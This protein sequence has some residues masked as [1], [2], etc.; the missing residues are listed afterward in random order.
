MIPI[1]DLLHLKP[2]TTVDSRVL[3]ELL[4]LAFAGRDTDRSI[5]Q[6]MATTTESSPWNAEFFGRDLFLDSLIEDVCRLSFASKQYAVHR[7]FLVRTLASP[8][9]DREEIRF[10]QEI[11][12]ELATRDE[13]R[14]GAVDLYTDLYDLMNMFKVPGRQARLD[15]ETFRVDLLRLAKGAVDHMVERFADAESGLRRL[16]TVGREIQ[17]SDDYRVL[18]ALVDHVDHRVT[19]NVDLQIGSAGRLRSVKVRRVDENRD[20]P[21][22][23]SPLARWW[24]K[25]RCFFSYGSSL[26]DE[27]ILSRLVVSVF[28]SLGP[29]LQH[30]LQVLVHLELYLTN[31]SLKERAEAAGLTVCLAD[32]S[33]TPDET[34]DGHVWR[35]LF[36]PLL[37]KQEAVP[38]PCGLR[39]PGRDGITLLTGPNSGGKT[40]FLQALGLAQVLGQSGLYTCASEARLNLLRGLYVSLIE[41]EA[42]DH[43]EGRLGRE[44][45]RIRTMFDAM[46]PPSM[47]ILDELC[48][49][50]NPS[51]ATEVFSMVLELLSPLAPVAFI[52]TH[53][54]DYAQQLETSPPVDNLDFLQV[55]MGA[56]QR[57]TYQFVPGVATSS[58]ASAMAERMGVTFDEL[59]QVLRGRMGDG[60]GKG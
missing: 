44:L 39:R 37:L 34:A 9:M 24:D 31:L 58:M 15:I 43:A 23:R 18:A 4:G 8:P 60:K 33:G 12:G 3:G 29:S 35:D 17:G 53:F 46:Q 7:A 49:G 28:E 48:S 32:F 38:V 1:P 51:E 40:R 5:E 2:R 20:N 6:A 25:V 13:L 36:N 54:L 59:S 16:S 56:D 10:R 41:H 11:V 57:S 45:E 19:L 42:V 27:D 26:K 14:Q 22:F 30:L 55:E 21:F 52:S 47:V 50:T